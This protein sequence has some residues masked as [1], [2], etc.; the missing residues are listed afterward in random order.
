M[1]SSRTR[2]IA[3]GSNVGDE[4]RAKRREAAFG[5]S[6]RSTGWATARLARVLR[7]FA[8]GSQ[9]QAS[10]SRL[11]ARTRAADAGRPSRALPYRARSSSADRACTVPSLAGHPLA[12]EGRAARRALRSCRANASATAVRGKALAKQQSL[13]LVPSRGD[14]TVSGPPTDG[15]L[16]RERLEIRRAATRDGSAGLRAHEERAVSSLDHS[17]TRTTCLTNWGPTFDMSGGPKDAKRPLGRPLDGGVRPHR[18]D[19]A[20]CV[21]RPANAPAKPRRSQACTR[22]DSTTALRKALASRP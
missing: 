15:R 16:G 20:S 10:T 22:G 19:S 5:T 7:A 4:R 12:A 18:S 2:C 6:A 17:A 9:G 1:S 8:D 11:T 3:V 14:P 21:P 13:W